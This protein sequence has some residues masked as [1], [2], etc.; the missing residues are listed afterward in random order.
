M[1]STLSPLLLMRFLS[2]QV[3]RPAEKIPDKFFIA[4]FINKKN[5]PEEIQAS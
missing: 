3:A 4:S 1:I 5:S 2:A